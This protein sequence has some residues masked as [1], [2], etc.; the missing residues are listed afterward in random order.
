M[1]F[2]YIC[3]NLHPFHYDQHPSV[4]SVLGYEDRFCVSLLFPK[5]RDVFKSIRLMDNN[6]R[7]KQTV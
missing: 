6:F 5:N 1:T 3:Y 4:R 2:W 7:P